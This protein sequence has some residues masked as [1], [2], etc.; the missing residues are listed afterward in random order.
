MRL[1]T[2]LIL[3]FILSCSD[4]T[5]KNE[6]SI[7]ES[8]QED[9]VSILDS[10]WYAEQEPIR[11]RDSLGKVHGYESEAFK[12]QNEIYHKN[13]AIN[14]EKIIAILDH[15][16]WPSKNIIGEQGQI[17]IC[18]VL[19]HS[20]IEIRIKYLPMMRKAVEEKELMPRLLA[21]AEDRLATDRGDL[22][23]YGGQI[24]YYPETKS[25]NVWPIKDPANVDQRREK[26]GLQP[27][28]TF[29]SNLRNPIDWNLEEQIKRTAEFTKEK[30]EKENVG[31]LN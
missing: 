31:N 2:L 5:G 14:E 20:S 16:G 11:L 27:I 7:S 8:P 23:L 21:R 3:V 1:V 6:A 25:F 4:K 18:N 24:K 26:I 15:Q 12:K 19:Q 22:Q 9:L 17:T 28:E 29:L 30:L 10:I 13:H